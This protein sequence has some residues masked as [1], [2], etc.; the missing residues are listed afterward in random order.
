MT[1]GSQLPVPYAVSGTLTLR[2]GTALGFSRRGEIPVT[3]FEGAL[4]A[5]P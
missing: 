3:R 2:N 5:R 4:G 1:L